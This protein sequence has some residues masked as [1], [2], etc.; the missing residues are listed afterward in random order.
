MVNLALVLFGF[1]ILDSVSVFQGQKTAVSVSVFG[2]IL[3]NTQFET[4]VV[5]IHFLLREFVHAIT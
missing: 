3:R 2:Q 5:L 1:Q 4:R